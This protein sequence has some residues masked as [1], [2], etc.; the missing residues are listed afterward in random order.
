[1]LLFLPMGTHQKSDLILIIL[2]PQKICKT[3]SL[4][5]RYMFGR[6]MLDE[7]TANVKSRKDISAVFISI[8]MVTGEQLSTLQKLWGLPV[9]D[10]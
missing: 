8:N 2:L 7:L 6:G 9:Y 3:K 5:T 10:R 1:M 4:N